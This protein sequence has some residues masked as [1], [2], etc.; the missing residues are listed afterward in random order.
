MKLLLDTD[1]L[2]WFI[3]GDSK[4]SLNARLLIEDA[5]NDKFVSVVSLWEIA[6]KYGLGR[7]RLSDDFET[8]FPH[9]LIINGF[10]QLAIENKHF[11]EFI[12]LPQHHNDPFDRLLIAQTISEKMSVVSVDSAFDNYPVS[13][14]W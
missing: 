7:L 10:E 4:L 1:T 12:K 2:L 3:T 11:Y 14:S 8:L 5:A 6:I 9:Q 13:R